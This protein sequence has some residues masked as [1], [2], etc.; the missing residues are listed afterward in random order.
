MVV[1]LN[2]TEKV[3]DFEVPE[4]MRWEGEGKD[5]IGNGKREKAVLEGGKIRLEAWEGVVVVL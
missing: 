5:W 4:G 2:F 3:V 1:L